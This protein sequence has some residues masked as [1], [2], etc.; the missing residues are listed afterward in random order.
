MRA[1]SYIIRKNL[2]FYQ[3]PTPNLGGCRCFLLY[4]KLLTMRAISYIIR[5]NLTF[6]QPPTPNLG[7]CRCFLLYAKLLTM[8]AISYIIIKKPTASPWILSVI[9]IYLL[10]PS[11]DN[12]DKGHKVRNL[13][14]CDIITTVCKHLSH[15]ALL[16]DCPY[17]HLKPLGVKHIN[18]KTGA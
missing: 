11:S 2:T 13:S 14:C 15:S 10:K 9:F 17:R 3:P 7:G 18:H 6:Y 4:A 16:I 12:T 1:I 5:K 8:R